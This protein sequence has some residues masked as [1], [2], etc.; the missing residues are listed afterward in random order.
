MSWALTMG[1]C[2]PVGCGFDNRKIF[3][4]HSNRKP[5]G[6]RLQQRGWF[7]HTLL[8]FSMPADA[9]GGLSAAEVAELTLSGWRDRAVFSLW[10][11]SGIGFFVLRTRPYLCR[12]KLIRF[13]VRGD[14]WSWLLR[15][16]GR[17]TELRPNGVVALAAL[18]RGDFHRIGAIEKTVPLLDA[19]GASARRHVT[20][21]A[22]TNANSV[23]GDSQ[24]FLLSP[25]SRSTS[26]AS[27]DTYRQPTSVDPLCCA[28][29]NSMIGQAQ[30]SHSKA[31]ANPSRR[32][33]GFAASS[34]DTKCVV[35]IPPLTAVIEVFGSSSARSNTVTRPW[36]RYS[37]P[38]Y[39]QASI[40]VPRP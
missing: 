34:D 1:G 24:T 8:G 4:K 17:E 22:P 16:F 20:V 15:V 23:L 21:T 6:R 14:C 31:I 37:P 28:K 38:Q 27:S 25:A 5:L 2:L 13:F 18:G 36:W 3:R 10:P 33:D 12:G 11:A 29:V 26:G 39:G 30:V 7:V 35:L 19:S 9:V 32:S 40:N